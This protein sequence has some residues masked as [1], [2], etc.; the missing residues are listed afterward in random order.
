MLPTPLPLLLLVLPPFLQWP[1]AKWADIG[2]DE[3]VDP[4]VEA[5]R[6]EV[7]L[8]VKRDED[9]ENGDRGGP[10]GSL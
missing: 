9:V 5:D 2:V 1:H 3:L 10:G 7:S 4:E 6:E 8:M